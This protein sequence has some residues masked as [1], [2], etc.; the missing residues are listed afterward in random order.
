[1]SL[2]AH[3]T[4][5]KMMVGTQTMGLGVGTVPCAEAFQETIKPSYPGG[6]QKAPKPHVCYGNDDRHCSPLSAG[7]DLILEDVNLESE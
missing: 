7:D 3:C 6:K 2:G 4:P 5:S 1:M